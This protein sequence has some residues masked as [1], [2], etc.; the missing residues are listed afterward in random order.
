LGVSELVGAVVVRDR[1]AGLDHH[2]PE[3]R[4][5]AES[6]QR[7]IPLAIPPARESSSGIRLRL[8]LHRIARDGK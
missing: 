5:E 8:Y 4:L 6:G 1:R 2:E 3:M 7:P